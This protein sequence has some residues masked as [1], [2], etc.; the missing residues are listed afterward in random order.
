MDELYFRLNYLLDCYLNKK[1]TDQEKDELFGFIRQ[2]KTDE[3]LNQML[4]HAWNN[5]RAEEIFEPAKSKQLLNNILSQPDQE[6]NSI[7]PNNN[8]HFFFA[9]AIV[10]LF[11][12]FAMAF[13]NQKKRKPNQIITKVKPFYHILP[14]SNKAVLKLA[15][16][17]SFILDDAKVGTIA[18]LENTRIKKAQDGL[19]VYNTN[20]PDLNKSSTINTVTTPR[21]GEY[22]IVL[23]D[24]SKVWLNAASSLSFPTQFTGKVR[25]VSISGEAYFEVAKN[26]AAP[27]RIKTERAEIEV[28]GTHFNVMAYTDEQEMKTTLLKGAIRI[29]SKNNTNIL[30]PGQQALVNTAGQQ[31]IDN[32][33][34]LDDA[35][36]WKNGMFQFK[37]ASIQEIM[38]QVSRWYNVPVSFEGKITKRQFTGRIARNVKAPALLAMLQ[39]MGVQVVFR[40]DQIIVRD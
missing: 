8:P 30:N 33:A 27:F 34:D 21:G 23:P 16:G 15:N 29:S 28:L 11:L 36:A 32:E 2:S 18:N 31:T 1:A 35:V 17:K 19:L 39:Y 38:R 14:G 3:S 22:Q 10:I 13:L 6:N 7:K 4:L 24:G 5:L 25:Q 20:R 37:D 26:A 12:G 9:A 40:N